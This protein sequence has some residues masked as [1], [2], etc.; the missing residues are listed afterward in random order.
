MIIQDS[1]DI[2]PTLTT[3][4]VTRTLIGND[5]ILCGNVRRI[6]YQVTPMKDSSHPLRDG[7][8]YVICA[9]LSGSASCYPGQAEPGT[10][11][12]QMAVTT[13]PPAPGFLTIHAKFHRTTELLRV[14]QAGTEANGAVATM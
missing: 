1:F 8:P 14:A 10:H 11:C 2:H 7:Q 12:W 6:W 4:L 13:P 9:S 3:G 5:Q